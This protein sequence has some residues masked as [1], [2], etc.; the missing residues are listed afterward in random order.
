MAETT[1]THEAERLTE[2]WRCTACAELWEFT[3]HN[4]DVEKGCPECR[5]PLRRI[6][7]P[8]AIGDNSG[9]RALVAVSDDQQWLVVHW[10]DFRAPWMVLQRLEEFDGY[11]AT[12]NTYEDIGQNAWDVLAAFLATSRERRAIHLAH[13]AAD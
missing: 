2:L 11:S 8:P 5:R 9:V 1:T 4:G 7:S 10:A 12:G 6:S 3:Q 13:T